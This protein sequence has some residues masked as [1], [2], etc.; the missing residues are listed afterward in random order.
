M[1]RLLSTIIFRDNW[2]KL[3]VSVKILVEQSR[4]EIYMFKFLANCLNRATFFIFI[5]Q[6]VRSWRWKIDH[7]LFGL[8]FSVIIR[9]TY[10][11][12]KQTFPCR[13]RCLVTPMMMIFISTRRLY[14]CISEISGSENCNSIPSGIL[15]AT[16]SQPVYITLV[17]ISHNIALNVTR[18]HF[19]EMQFFVLRI[20]SNGAEEVSRLIFALSHFANF[21]AIG[22]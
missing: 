5:A 19:S 1:R 14:S 13:C 4:R 17:F 20:T 21:S 10:P 6:D 9:A 7:L 2:W 18:T 11:Q 16:C 3:F 22:N 15:R 12:F 8:I